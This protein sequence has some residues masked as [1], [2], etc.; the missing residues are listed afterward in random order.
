MTRWRISWKLAAVTGSGKV[1]LRA[2]TGG[3]PISLGSML[4][5]GEMTERAA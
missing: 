4:A 3:I 1:S 5:S 2:K